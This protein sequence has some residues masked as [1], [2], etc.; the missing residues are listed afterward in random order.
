MDQNTEKKRQELLQFIK[1]VGAPHIY[2][3]YNFY[4][5]ECGCDALIPD[6]A[7]DPVLD[8]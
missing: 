2:T 3:M 6:G 5:K 1:T 8:A 4:L 7:E